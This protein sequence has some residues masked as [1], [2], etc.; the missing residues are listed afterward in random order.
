[1]TSKGPAVVNTV[2]AGAISRRLKDKEAE[3]VAPLS[4]EVRLRV[5][6]TACEVVP[7]AKG[8]AVE[9]MTRLPALKVTP[10]IAG[11]IE[12]ESTVNPV[13]IVTGIEYAVPAARVSWPLES[14][15][16]MA[17]VGLETVKTKF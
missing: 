11:V 16:A 13:G 15:A 12:M 3:I 6:V 14:N 2:G 9:E 5:R 10:E 17:K 8:A 7:L 4:P 1:L